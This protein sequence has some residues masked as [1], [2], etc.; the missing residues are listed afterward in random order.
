MN[1]REVV[2]SLRSHGEN[3]VKL[4]GKQGLSHS[5][6]HSC[7]L[8][9]QRTH[10]ETEHLVGRTSQVHGVQIQGEDSTGGSTCT[11]NAQFRGPLISRLHKDQASPETYSVA[12]VG[13]RVSLHPQG[14][15]EASS[16]G[17]VLFSCS[18]TVS[19]SRTG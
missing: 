12:G 2:T 9:T 17:T 8:P 1:I 16:A 10:S 5:R 15:R 7:K 19:A 11:S 4:G 13:T 6:P 3:V 18:G 14:P